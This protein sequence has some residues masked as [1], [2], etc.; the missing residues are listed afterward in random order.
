MDEQKL[1]SEFHKLIDSFQDT[2]VLESIYEAINDLK[3]SET[4]ILD[5]LNEEQFKRLH[6]SVVQA[7]NGDVIKNNDM[8]EKINKW[9]TK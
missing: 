2:G 9:L 5:D 6:K 7:E 8:R 4:D 1:K 3:N